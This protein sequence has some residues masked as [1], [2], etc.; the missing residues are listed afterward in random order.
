[1]E[2][3]PTA[4]PAGSTPPH[5]ISACQICGAPAPLVP[6]LSDTVMGYRLLRDPW[7][8]RPSFLD[9]N[10]HF[11]CLERSDKNA[12]F[13]EEF[14]RMLR[15]GHEEVASVDGSLPPLTRTGLSMWEVF[16]GV[17]CSVF[18]SG[19]ADRWLVV[20]RTGP[21]FGLGLDDLRDIARGGTPVSPAHVIPYR[22]PSD[23]AGS[24]EAYDL[25]GLLTALGVADA[26]P[27]GLLARV[28]YEFVDY[29]PPKRILEYVARTPLPIP[30]EARAFLAE[31]IAH[32]R[33]V[34]FGEGEDEG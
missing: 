25:P 33:P 16:R 10:L 5:G 9:G 32:C 18:Q 2:G 3:G 13:H 11:S 29:Y 20:K 12:V 14:T 4:A 34:E 19:L 31:H 17:E 24:I 6:G 15:A 23:L 8:D 30:E 1:M 21:W 7:S 22:L 27:A 26:Y 28:E